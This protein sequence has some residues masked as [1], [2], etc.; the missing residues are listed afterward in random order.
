MYR[1]ITLAP[2]LSKLYELVLLRLYEQHL[3]SDPLQFGFKKKSSCIHALFTVPD[4]KVIKCFVG[5]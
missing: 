5:F 1:G 4:R 3:G 2:V